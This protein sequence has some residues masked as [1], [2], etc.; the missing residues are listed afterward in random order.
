MPPQLQHIF[1][2]IIYQCYS[3]IHHKILHITVYNVIITIDYYHDYFNNNRLCITIN[4]MLFVASSKCVSQTL[5]NNHMQHD[6]LMIST[7]AV[8]CTYNGKSYIMLH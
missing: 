1:Q 4:I 5:A 7:S 8:N 2:S 6:K 3:C